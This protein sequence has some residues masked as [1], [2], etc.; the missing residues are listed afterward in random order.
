[1]AS[2]FVGRGRFVG[3]GGEITVKIHGRN[4]VHI[5]RVGL[6]Y[7]QCMRCKHEADLC[8]E[9]DHEFALCEGCLLAWDLEQ[10]G[11]ADKWSPKLARHY[12]RAFWG[13]YMYAA[14][15]TPQEREYWRMERELAKEFLRALTEALAN[16]ENAEQVRW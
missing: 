2:P 13:A 7:A 4:I 8:D 6:R 14:D 1:M 16:A 5:S 11:L 15:V 9:Q 10:S 12:W 3:V